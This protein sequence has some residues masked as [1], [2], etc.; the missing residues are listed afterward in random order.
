MDFYSFMKLAQN[1]E[2][3]DKKFQP[4]VLSSSYLTNITGGQTDIWHY[5]VAS[6]FKNAEYPYL[7]LIL[8][9]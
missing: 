2:N 3:V 5:R 8:L 4:S 7:T 6:L 9:R 1:D